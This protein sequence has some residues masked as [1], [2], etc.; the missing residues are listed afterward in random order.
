MRNCNCIC[1]KA[2]LMKESLLTHQT[3]PTLEN[4][5]NTLLLA[6]YWASL[7]NPYCPS[8]IPS[9]QSW[10]CITIGHPHCHPHHLFHYPPFCLLFQLIPS[11]PFFLLILLQGVFN[12]KA[13]G[14][15]YS[16]TCRNVAVSSYLDHVQ[17]HIVSTFQFWATSRSWD[18]DRSR[19]TYSDS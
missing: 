16:V 14:Y 4:I 8:A 10:P 1:K 15:A 17:N 7:L 3:K 12:N 13:C 9:H 18:F 5:P 6:C 19:N 11:Q 2:N